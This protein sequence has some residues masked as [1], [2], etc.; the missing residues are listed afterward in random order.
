MA[1]RV[2]ALVSGDTLHD[3]QCAWLDRLWIC[4]VFRRHNY[5]GPGRRETYKCRFYAAKFLEATGYGNPN[6][7]RDHWRFLRWIQTLMVH[8]TA[9]SPGHLGGGFCGDV[10]HNY[11]M[12]MLVT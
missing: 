7:D 2:A 5:P 9:G 1:S 4:D 12:T 8:H 11:W 6:K 3:G 10:R